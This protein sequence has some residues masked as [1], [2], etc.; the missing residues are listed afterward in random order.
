[1]KFEIGQ[2]VR[3]LARY[4]VPSGVAYVVKTTSGIF[5]GRPTLFVALT[6]ADDGVDYG[7]ET[8]ATFTDGVALL[9][10][11]DAFPPATTEGGRDDG[12]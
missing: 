9:T 7:C 3:V 6:R 11:R 10:A 5:T 12:P 2:R 1:M 8:W 4:G